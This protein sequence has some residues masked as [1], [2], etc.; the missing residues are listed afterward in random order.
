MNICAI[1]LFVGYGSCIAAKG[2]VEQTKKS[3]REENIEKI[4]HT[5]N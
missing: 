4:T 5:S 1:K 2:F 3:D